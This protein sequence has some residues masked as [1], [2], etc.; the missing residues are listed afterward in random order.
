[1]AKKGHDQWYESLIQEIEALFKPD[2][3]VSDKPLLG[4]FLLGYHCQQKDFWD[5]IAKLKAKKE[6]EPTN[7]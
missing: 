3:F 4:D 7:D 5:G 2:D 6:S 1:L